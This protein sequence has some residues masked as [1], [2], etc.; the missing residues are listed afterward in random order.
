MFY[1]LFEKRID[2]ILLTGYLIKF[3]EINNIIMRIPIRA[4]IN[5]TSAIVSNRNSFLSFFVRI[6]MKEKMQESVNNIATTEV[7]SSIIFVSIVLE[8]CREVIT[9]RQKPNKFADVF[10]TC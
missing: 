3:R 10:N 5:K 8:I 2:S 4:I 7:N 1:S 6:D 9:K